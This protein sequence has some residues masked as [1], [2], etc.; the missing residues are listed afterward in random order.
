MS[1]FLQR[2]FINALIMEN[3]QTKREDFIKR[4]RVSQQH[5]KERL[6]ILEK[7]LRKKYRLRTGKEAIK[8]CAL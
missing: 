3:L 5:K 8:F 2:L 6:A 1:V 7:V 4:L